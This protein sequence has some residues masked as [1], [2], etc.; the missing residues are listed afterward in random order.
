MLSTK[1]VALV[2]DLANQEGLRFLRLWSGA[3]LRKVNHAAVVEVLLKVEFDCN[4]GHERQ[5]AAFD[6]VLDK[7]PYHVVEP[8]L[9]SMDYEG[10]VVLVALKVE[11]EVV[12]HPRDLLL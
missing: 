4:V 6:G 5:E 1:H 9:L 10:H 2:Y 7:L 3:H 12:L 8:V 11:F